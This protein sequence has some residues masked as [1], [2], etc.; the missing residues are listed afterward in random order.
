MS[1]KSKGMGKLKA[2]FGA[3]AGLL[4]GAVIMYVTPLVDKVVK[5]P[6]PLANFEARQDGLNVSF[7]NLS[8]GP[9]NLSGWWDFGDGSALV[10]LVPDQDVTHS[11]AKPGGYSAKL[12]VR[13]VLGDANER[14]VTLQIET[15]SS[16][17]EPPRILTLDAV[18]LTPGSLAPA[19]FKI[20][21]E[22][23]GAQQAVWDLD[24]DRPLEVNVPSPGRQERL[25][26]FSRPGN[27]TIK[28]AAFNGEQHDQKNVLVSVRPAPAGALSAILTSNVQ[29]SLVE[30]KDRKLNFAAS[31]PPGE[32]G[33]AHS[34]G[35][36]L[37][38]TPG[39]TVADV[40]IAQPR[41][42][43]PWMQGKASMPVD[44]SAFK[45]A[46]VRSLQIS[47]DA[48]GKLVRLA[49]ELVRNSEKEW[50]GMVLPVVL[51]EERKKP[52][53]TLNPLE[54][55]AP[56]TLPGTA[57]L[58]LPPLPAGWQDAKR[59]ISLKLKD[60]NNVVWEDTRVPVTA[61]LTSHGR[62]YFLSAAQNGNNV[63]IN[64]TE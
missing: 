40:Q 11:Y 32:K 52:V 50:P 46:A 17:A 45:I 18:P 30:R 7:H 9:S 54:V 43:G 33:K 12:S 38:P 28:L 4:S 29:A 23:K 39:W 21:T 41:T 34:F 24:A 48:D 62:R 37:K 8:S 26:T 63:Q 55:M 47:R 25:I 27:Y 61:V 58:M 16:G 5:P 15:A 20:A 31:F 42:E 10:P 19:T 57:S 22:M 2:M 35:L 36:T 1:E 13:N 59:Q 53:K 64:V 60:G 56:L 51:R 49:G 14:S 6:A 3:A 44:A